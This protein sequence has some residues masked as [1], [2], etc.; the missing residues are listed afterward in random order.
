MCS[1]METD[2]SSFP[3]YP[4]VN[5][6]GREE[7][8]GACSQRPC[9]RG[10][11][12]RDLPDGSFSCD[13]PLRATGPQCETELPPPYETP[14]FS[15]S[16]FLEVKKIKAYNK[17]QVELEFRTFTDSGILLYSQQ[18]RDGS[19]DFLSLALVDGFVE[20]RYNLGSGPALI[21][22]HERIQMKRFHRV[23]DFLVTFDIY[24]AMP[25]MTMK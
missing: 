22:S 17:V 4:T 18:Q 25:V 13:C 1:V 23:S 12:C 9:Q 16:S 5:T 19:G 20:F 15:G 3:A 10:G 14:S 2:F 7:A 21:R 8:S 6:P 11:I 24:N